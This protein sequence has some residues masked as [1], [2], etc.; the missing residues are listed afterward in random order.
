MSLNSDATE[1]KDWTESA[2]NALNMCLAN[3]SEG[4]RLGEQAR[5]DII[6]SIIT[7]YVWIVQKDQAS[8]EKWYVEGG[9]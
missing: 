5:R 4:S 6:Q 9:L 8:V 1:M 7:Y 3:T 2:Q